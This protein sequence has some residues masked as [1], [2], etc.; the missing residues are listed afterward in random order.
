MGKESRT[1]NK[2][3]A[4]SFLGF[5]SHIPYSRL[6]GNMNPEI[7]CGHRE[8]IPQEKPLLLVQGVRGTLRDRENGG[9][10]LFFLLL[11]SPSCPAPRQA[12]GME[13]VILFSGNSSKGQV[14]SQTFFPARGTIV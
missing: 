1:L 6:M 8:K 3:E 12:V 13:A 7:A 14:A 11:F 5:Y 2:I 10:P 9:N 4:M